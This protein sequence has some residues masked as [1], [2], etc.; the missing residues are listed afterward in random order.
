MRRDQGK[1]GRNLGA[2]DE[3]LRNDRTKSVAERGK[4]MDR[5]QRKKGEGYTVVGNDGRMEVN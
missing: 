1:M 5:E 2:G 3:V 4:T